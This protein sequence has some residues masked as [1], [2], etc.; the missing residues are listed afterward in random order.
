M[1]IDDN[2]YES[3][4]PIKSPTPT[5]PESLLTVTMDRTSLT[6]YGRRFVLLSLCSSV[7]VFL[8]WCIIDVISV[9]VLRDPLRLGDFYWTISLVPA[10]FLAHAVWF[11]W[12]A[13]ASDRIWLAAGSL[14]LT[15]I[16]TTVLI[17][18]IGF[19]FHFAIGG[20]P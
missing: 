3:P 19:P 9:R 5:A 15:T 12:E 14:T 18:L 13:E 2:P 4:K 20:T 6:R 17:V 1:F 7:A 16:L 10:A 8:A 11:F